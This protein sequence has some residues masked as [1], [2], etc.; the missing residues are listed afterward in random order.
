MNLR[1]LFDSALALAP[2]AR[3]G[4]STRSARTLA[5]RA[6]VE[7]LLRAHASEDEPVSSASVE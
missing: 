5:V 4:F 6:S 2:A 3:A 7:S 1:E